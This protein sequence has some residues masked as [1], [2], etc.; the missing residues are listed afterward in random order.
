MNTT[1]RLTL[2]CL[3]AAVTAATAGC[4]NAPALLT[5]Q[6]E[7][8]RLASDLRVQI[9][10]GAE[11]ANR[12]VMAADD[13]ASAAAAR[14]AQQATQAADRDVEQLRPI[15]GSLGYSEDLRL[16]DAFAERFTEYKTL[17]AEILPLAAENTNLK[18]QQ[19][20]FGPARE[21]SKAFRD[22]LAGAVRAAPARDARAVEALAA[23]AG[24]AVLEV[25]VLH[26]PH[27][28]EADDAAMARLEEE[29]AAS[30]ATARRA[31]GELRKVLGTAGAAQMSAA[32]E[33]LDRF[34]KINAELVTLSR[35]NSNVR[36][37][38]LS[39]GRKRTVTALCDDQLRAL[40]EALA[41]HAFS[42]TR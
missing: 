31:L 19:L 15:L 38:A 30:R 10:K 2:S 34:E 40:E 24:A 35:R 3:L 32:T 41:K 23:H 33:A 29:M 9:S 20:S 37:L 18:A 8:R 21:A 12:A 22:A 26:A 4:V 5:Q 6:A 1:F 36:S 42:A 7:A 17:D 16:L 11:A 39:L 27:I 28:A 13:E 25:Q 14:E